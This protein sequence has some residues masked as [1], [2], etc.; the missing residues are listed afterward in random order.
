[1]IVLDEIKAKLKNLSE[2]FDECVEAI[3]LTKLKAREAELDELQ[4]DPDLFKDLKRAQEINSEAK[5]IIQEE[6]G[7]L[8]ALHRFLT[9]MIEDSKLINPVN[10]TNI[11]VLLASSRNKDNTAQLENQLGDWHQFFSIMKHYTIVGETEKQ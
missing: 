4:Q 3:D 7:H 10:I 1:M 2:K 6:V 8:Q 9:D 11:K 5:K